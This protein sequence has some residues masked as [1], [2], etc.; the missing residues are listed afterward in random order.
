MTDYDYY[1]Q[2]YG[3]EEVEKWLNE[4][5]MEE[6]FDVMHIFSNRSFNGISEEWNLHRD[7]C[8][9]VLEMILQETPSCLYPSVTYGTCPSANCRDAIGHLTGKVYGNVDIVIFLIQQKISDLKKWLLENYEFSEWE[10]RVL[11]Y[12]FGE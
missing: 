6:L 4:V 11:H 2:K 12:D 1:C 3:Q 5:D 7:K 8:L 10:R 9:N